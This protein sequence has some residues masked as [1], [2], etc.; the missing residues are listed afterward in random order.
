MYALAS[1]D[2]GDEGELVAVLKRSIGLRV[3]AVEGEGDVVEMI[4]QRGGL[5][6]ELF[7]GGG[8]GGFFGEIQFEP[9]G[10]GAVFEEGEEANGDTHEE[11]GSA[12]PTLDFPCR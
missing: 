10:A 7:D 1:G 3:G 5:V 12:H 4:S 9:V 6:A 2:R 11:V 8:D